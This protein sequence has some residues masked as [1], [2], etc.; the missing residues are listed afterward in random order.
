MSISPFDTGMGLSVNPVIP[1]AVVPT[2]VEDGLQPVPYTKP[3]VI[4]DFDLGFQLPEANQIEQK[5]GLAAINTE[6]LHD[7]MRDS[8]DAR[9]NQ[10][11][12]NTSIMQ[13]TLTDQL[14]TLLSGTQQNTTLLQQNLVSAVTSQMAIPLDQ[15]ILTA[16]GLPAVQSLIG[17]PPMPP[18]PIAASSALIGP[19][20]WGPACSE[21][22]SLTISEFQ[23]KYGPPGVVHVTGGIPP[24]QTGWHWGLL[25]V[26]NPPMKI[27]TIFMDNPP[28]IG[29]PPYTCSPSSGIIA[30]P[31]LPPVP[32]IITPLPPT[33]LPPTP[34]YQPVPPT[35]PCPPV[36]KFPDCIKICKDEVPASKPCKY[37]LYCTDKGTLYIIRDTDQPKSTTDTKLQCGDPLEWNLQKLIDQCSKPSTDQQ[38]QATPYDQPPQ[39]ATGV[40]CDDLFAFPFLRNPASFT[41]F[42]DLMK[43]A[44]IR[45]GNQP[46]SGLTWLDNAA[47]AIFTMLRSNLGEFG[48]SL[49]DSIVS[50]VGTGGCSTPNQI[51]IIGMRALL[52]IVRRYVSDAAEGPDTQAA[53]AQN[54]NCPWKL[55]S[56]EA[57]TGMYLA[58][59]IT[60]ERLRCLVQANGNL[61]GPWQQYVDANRTRWNAAETMMLWRRNFISKPFAYDYLRQLGYLS[62]LEKEG[63]EKLTEQVPVVS[64]LMSMMIRDVADETTINWKTSD[65]LFKLK[66][67]GQLQKWGQMQGVPD[68]MAQ[69]IWRAHWILPSP[70]QLFEF[71][72]RLRKSGKYGTEDEFKAK[73]ENH[74]RQADYHPDW[75]SAYMDVAFNP[76]TRV[77]A[78]RAFEVGAIDKSK[79]QEAYTNL[80]YSDDNANILVDFKT[81]QITQK[82][83]KSTYVKQFAEGDFNESE[84]RDLLSAT[85]LPYVVVSSCVDHGKNLLKINRRKICVKSYHKRFLLGEFDLPTVASKLS[86]DGLDAVQINE[87]S[88]AWECE[89]K[90][91][92]KAVPMSILCGWYERGV[93][94]E[95]ELYTRAKTLGYTEDDAAKLTRDCMTRV[96]MKLDREKVKAMEKAVRQTRQ[97]AKAAEQAQKQFDQAIEANNKKFQKAAKTNQDRMKLLIK[98]AEVWSKKTNTLLPDSVVGLKAIL[99]KAIASG[100][101]P[102]NVIYQGLASLAEDPNVIDLPTFASELSALLVD[103]S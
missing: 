65:D 75:I 39:I 76:L 25:E 69:Y 34:P 33:P 54:Y 16:P 70:T 10:M 3:I 50:V 77:D 41:Y 96:G 43:Q 68:L 60:L 79:L 98:A 85:G 52:G 45:A 46:S 40:G 2:T 22:A 28:G 63:L 24:D 91:R 51:A 32:P 84:L 42:T 44:E 13:S 62:D 23:A 47:N 92:G 53:Y 27:I 95:V 101:A 21:I 1:T 66:W 93:I 82:W 48:D 87:I 89:R 37:C 49:L 14:H 64:D 83:M 30:R 74:L 78:G 19:R 18:A 8:L 57:A 12:T 80:G 36:I 56:A 20:S 31:A 35:T 55:P 72:R 102:I 58:N 11:Q 9:L 100:L 59:S 61:W 29:P 81:K 17:P 73:I 4:P 15:T 7:A 67:S 97:A 71:W 99:N 88:N 6:T 5:L 94:D 26:G 103:V 90:Q 38:S 86:A